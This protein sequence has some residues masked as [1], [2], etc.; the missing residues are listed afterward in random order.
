MIKLM[1]EDTL[2][3]GIVESVLDV[4]EEFVDGIEDNLAVS[5]GSKVKGYD[6]DWC[7]DVESS[8]LKKAR[9]AYIQ[10]LV[11]DLFDKFE[12]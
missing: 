8:D 9:E 5:V 2:N 11:A 6:A 7:A 10:A 12:V 3:D 1:V 4:L